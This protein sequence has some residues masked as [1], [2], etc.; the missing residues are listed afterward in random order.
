M[1][2]SLDSVTRNPQELQRF[3]MQNL[4]LPNSTAQALLAAHV[5]PPE[6]RQGVVSLD[7]SSRGTKGLEPSWLSCTPCPQVYHLIFGPVP[8]LDRKSGF[9]RSQEPWSHL[10]SRPLF[11]MEVR[12]PSV[13]GD[14]PPASSWVLPKGP[15]SQ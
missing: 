14:V 9:P 7:Y 5:D 1:P 10:G 12:G 2:F 4:S 15:D 6:V 11:Q 3:L 8:N 13:G